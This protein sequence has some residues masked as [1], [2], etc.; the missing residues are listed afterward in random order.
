MHTPSRP[1]VRALAPRL[2]PRAEGTATEAT[3]ETLHSRKADSLYLRDFPVEDTHAGVAQDLG[4]LILPS[5]FIVVVP[6]NGNDGNLQGRGDLTAE[7][8][9]LVRSAVIGEI[10]A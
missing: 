4:N 3:G 8:A 7:D 10:S 9:G 5:G 2:A 1:P 6:Q